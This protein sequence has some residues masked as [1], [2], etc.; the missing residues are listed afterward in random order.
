M[1][2]KNKRFGRLLIITASVAISVCSCL[3]PHSAKVE[4]Q[5]EGNLRSD[6]GK[7]SEKNKRI[8]KIYF[9]GFDALAHVGEK[10]TLRAKVE[11]RYLRR[12]IE[13]ETVEFYVEGTFIGSAQTDNEGFGAISFIP[14]KLGEFEIL[15]KLG[16]GPRYEPK[17]TTGLLAVRN[18]GRPALVSDLDMTV[19]DISK[20]PFFV[21][22][23]NKIPAVAGALESMKRLAKSY[24]II[25]LSA[26]DDYH[27]NTIKKWMVSNGLPQGPIFLR[28]LSEDAAD[29]EK[30]KKKVLKEL[31]AK[32]PNIT[33]GI[34]NRSYDARSYLAN[35]M[36]AYILGWHLGLPEGAIG[37]KNWKQICEHLTEE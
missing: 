17:E 16:E 12:D 31:K 22:E 3:G 5:K 32:W 26:R 15:Y 18:E 8:V 4:D 28:D 37:V 13:K 24:D 30:Y 7:D 1:K 25:Y 29:E 6:S 9:S 2:Q 11:T 34:G 10:T 14:D 23:K 20:Y 27:L 33:I 35:G 21:W 19:I 36:E